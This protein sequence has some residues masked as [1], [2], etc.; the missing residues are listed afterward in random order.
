VFGSPETVRAGI[1]AVALE[2]GASEVMVV[3]IVHEHRA[4]RRSY[5]LIAE[6]F[7][8][9]RDAAGAGERRTVK[10]SASAV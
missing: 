6:A 4:R 2:Y 9:D 10:R 3:T 8:L 5:E 7:A 1:E